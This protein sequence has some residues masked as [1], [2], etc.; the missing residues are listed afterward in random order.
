MLSLLQQGAQGFAAMEAEAR[1]L[2]LALSPKQIAESRV[3]WEEYE[4]TLLSIKGLGKQIGTAFLEPLGL[5]ASGVKGFVATFKDDMIGGI[6][7]V[8]NSM[9]NFIKGA[10]DLFAKFGIP[11][12]NGFISFAGQIGEAFETLFNWLGP[13]TENSIGGL[14]S[15]F[16]GIT[17]FLATFKQSIII[18]IVTPI[19]FAIRGVVTNLTFLT[20][21]LGTILTEVAAGLE[22]IGV[23]EDSDVQAMA[24]IFGGLKRSIRAIGKDVA[25]PF[26]DAEETALKEMSDIF[27]AQDKKNSFQ[28]SKFKSFVADFSDKFG[29]AIE[30]LPV[31]AVD[32]AKEMARSISEK[33]AGLILSGSQAEQNIINQSQNKQLKLA[34]DSLREQ[35]K[36]NKNLENIGTF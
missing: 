19:Q 36:T 11:F 14:S 26:V 16:K 31:I 4:S 20:D 29:F 13:A 15:L 7:I 9:T 21:A 33:S 27:I 6:K 30:K 1:E 12:I 25:Q 23:A 34:Q 18:G 8:A 28:I 22:Q 10:F 5:M 24:D 2:G 32:A 3:A 35:K 17:S